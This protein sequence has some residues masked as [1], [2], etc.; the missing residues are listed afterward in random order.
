MEGVLIKYFLA[1]KLIF[2]TRRDR[3]KRVRESLESTL[4]ARIELMESYAKVNDKT[5]HG[6]AIHIFS[7]LNGADVLNMLS[8]LCSMIEI[9][10][11][12]DSDVIA[13]EAASSAVSSFCILLVNRIK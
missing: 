8:Q 6:T 3:V 11:E 7:P 4:L 5:V 2:S 1:H 12:M 10:V 13:A 9:E